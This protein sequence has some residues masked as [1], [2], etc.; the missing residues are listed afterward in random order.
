M[1]LHKITTKE[2]F[3]NVDVTLDHRKK[4]DEETE[5]NWNLICENKYWGD[6]IRM[7]NH[8]ARTRQKVASCSIT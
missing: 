8:L 5:W 1:S 4:V 6:I 2:K 3:K 7:K